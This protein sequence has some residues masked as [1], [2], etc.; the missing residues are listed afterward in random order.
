MAKRVR[1]NNLC[2]DAISLGKCFQLITNSASR[3]PLAESIAEEI[4][5]RAS[6]LYEPFVRLGLK[7][8]W[9]I[10]SSQFA[11][12]TVKIEVTS[13]NMFHLDLQKFRNAGSR[14]AQVAHNEVPVH[15]S[16]GLELATE[17]AVI[18][19]TYD[20]LQEVLLLNL[21]ELHF[22]PRL[23]DEVE[24]AIQGLQPQIYGLCLVVFNQP[25]LVG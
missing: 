17:E 4:A 13:L 3:D 2:V 19:V 14:R 5:A 22:Q 10:E 12:F 18:R 23:L 1:I 16:I 8:L 9:Y 11:T 6:C 25:P 7:A 20:V 15:A 21:D 24:I